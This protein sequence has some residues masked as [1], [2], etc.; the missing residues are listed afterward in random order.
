MKKM[1][2]Y[3]LEDIIIQDLE[4]FLESFMSDESI[5]QDIESNQSYVVKH[6][7]NMHKHILEDRIR[8]DIQS[9]RGNRDSITSEDDMKRRNINECPHCE[10]RFF[11]QSYMSKHMGN[12]H[13]DIL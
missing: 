11:N 6:L 4:S 10:K 5:M 8:Q 2:K 9:Q 13:R 3:I 1:H 7:V 12:M